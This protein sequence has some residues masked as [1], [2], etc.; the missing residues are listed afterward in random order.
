MLSSL[1]CLALAV[2]AFSFLAPSVMAV[3]A[4]P[5]IV[6]EIRVMDGAVSIEWGNAGTTDSYIVER[7][8]GRSRWSVA[9]TF[10]GHAGG[11]LNM[12]VQRRT[13]YSYRVRAVNSSGTSAYSNT[14]RVRTSSRTVPTTD[15]SYASAWVVPTTSGELG[16]ATMTS[17]IGS[18]SNWS[19]GSYGGSFSLVDSNRFSTV[20]GWTTVSPIANLSTGTLGY[21]SSDVLQINVGTIVPIGPIL[22]T[23]VFSPS[24]TPFNL[25]LPDF[26]TVFDTTTQTQTLFVSSVQ[27]AAR[28]T[29]IGAPV[30]ALGST[31]VEFEIGSWTLDGIVGT[32]RLSLSPAL[33]DA[34]LANA[35]AASSTLQFPPQ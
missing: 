12:A 10:P 20:D 23:L 31:R 3:P 30:I 28:L 22:G 33:Y 9:G 1:R 6:V 11:I 5:S 32:T 13:N 25:L 8:T 18:W 4:T 26:I 34:I 21:G 29:V 16:A 15:G 17:A 14:G 2:V 24:A 7:R 27:E 35:A 19:G